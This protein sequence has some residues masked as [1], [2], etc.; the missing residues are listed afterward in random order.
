MRVA[1]HITKNQRNRR[2]LTRHLYVQVA[3]SVANVNADDESFNVLPA[4]QWAGRPSCTAAPAIAARPRGPPCR[5]ETRNFKHGQGNKQKYKEHR[6][7][8][9]HLMWT[10]ASRTPSSASTWSCSE[11]VSPSCTA[12][13]SHCHYC[14]RYWRLS[15]KFAGQGMC[16]G[17][18]IHP[19]PACRCFTGRTL[20]F[21]NNRPEHERLS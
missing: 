16:R 21:C 6:Q 7:H 11:S 12:V 17:L 9:A 8:A 10:N 5:S 19:L 18:C 1:S 13:I 4:A 14:R 15:S 20:A 3:R 2:I